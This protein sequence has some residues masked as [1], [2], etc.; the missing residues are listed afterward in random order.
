MHTISNVPTCISNI[1]KSPN[2]IALGAVRGLFRLAEGKRDGHPPKMPRKLVSC[3][4]FL[5]C[6]IGEF[7]I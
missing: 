3:A 2:S 6:M 1:K 4:A 7:V 5:S